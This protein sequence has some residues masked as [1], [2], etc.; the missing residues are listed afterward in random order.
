M[1]AEG[2]RREPGLEEVEEHED[3]ELYD[4]TLTKK[5]KKNIKRFLK[6]FHS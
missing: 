3:S 4:E 5:N 2:G 6:S 1:L